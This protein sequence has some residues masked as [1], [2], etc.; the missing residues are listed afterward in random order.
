[1]AGLPK[2]PPA[3]RKRGRTQLRITIQRRWMRYL[4]YGV[5]G[6]TTLTVLVLTFASFSFS[7]MIDARLHGER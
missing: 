6:I 5:G 7:R 1:M 4:L 2:Q 3:A